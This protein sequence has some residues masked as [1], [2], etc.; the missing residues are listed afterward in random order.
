MAERPNVEKAKIVKA[1]NP[2][3]AV[4]CHFNPETFKLDRKVE[5]DVKT[6]IGG[7]VS[8]ISFKGGEAHKIGPV[9]LL[10]D[11]TATGKD[12][13]DEYKLLVE[14][15]QVDPQKKNTKTDK[16]EPSRVRFQWGKLI[17]FEAV[18]ESINQ[19]FTMFKAD[20]TP[21]R[22]KVSVSFIQVPEKVAGQ[23][24]TSRSESRKIWVVHEGQTLDWIAYQEYGDP[25]HWRYIAETNNLAN[26]KD[27]RPGQILKLVPLP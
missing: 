5:W 9:E 11:T 1:D 4:D 15:A 18:I 3:K 6:N 7:D 12:V 14:L 26:P 21:L 20:G 8:E 2:N 19:T 23:N 25:A 27:L 24:P 10:F 22:A 17:S 13:R 16:G